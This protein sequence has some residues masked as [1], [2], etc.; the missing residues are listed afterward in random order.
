MLRDNHILGRPS[1]EYIAEETPVPVYFNLHLALERIRAL[2]LPVIE[3]AKVEVQ[4]P[5]TGETSFEYEDDRPGPRVLLIGEQESGKTTLL[6]TLANWAIRSGRA[7]T[8][9]GNVARMEEPDEG[10]R[11]SRGVL[12]VNLDPA[13]VRHCHFV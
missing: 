4:D 11:R 10:E 9:V 1:T 6:K 7:R 13:E 5:A 2:A 8:E 3:A 12:V